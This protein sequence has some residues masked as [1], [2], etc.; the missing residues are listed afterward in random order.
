MIYTLLKYRISENH[1]TFPFSYQ[2]LLPSAY[3]MV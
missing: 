3:F 1:D 2:T